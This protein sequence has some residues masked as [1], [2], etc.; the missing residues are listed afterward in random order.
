VAPLLVLLGGI[1]V[2]D[3]PQVRE[4]PP[5]P[6]RVKPPGRLQQHRLGLGGGVGGQLGGAGRQHPRVRGRQLP[7]RKGPG[8]GG[9]GAAEQ[10]PGGADRL[11][12]RAAAEAELVAQPA[13]GGGLG[14]VLGAGGA[15]AVHARE[16]P[17]PLAFQ[18]VQQPPQH[19]H[20]RGRDRVGQGVQVLGGQLLDRGFQVAQPDR[21]HDGRRPRNRIYVRVHG[22]NLPVPRPA[23]KH[24]TQIVEGNFNWRIAEPQTD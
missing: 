14:V 15:A 18:P 8:G 23:F 2:G 13:C 3:R 20:P 22:R 1:R 9:E 4:D 17:Q 21:R 16:F 7:G 6:P 11:A 19:Q 24:P 10:G 12:G 5:Q